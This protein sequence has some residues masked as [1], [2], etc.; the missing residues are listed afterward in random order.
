MLRGAVAQAGVFAELALEPL[1]GR[2]LI[3]SGGVGAS[4]MRWARSIKALAAACPRRCAPGAGGHRP[5][6]GDV[7]KLVPDQPSACNIASAPSVRAWPPLRLRDQGVK[8][9]EA[10]GLVFQAM[11]GFRRIGNT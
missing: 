6:S 2:C 7:Q 9:L 8:A 1:T 3:P 10:V 5:A 11:P 4:M